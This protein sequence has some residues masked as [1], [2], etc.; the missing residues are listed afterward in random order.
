MKGCA[1]MFSV[2]DLKAY[3]LPVRRVRMSFSAAAR[4]R[5]IHLLA[6]GPCMVLIEIIV[7]Y[8]ARYPEMEPVL[9]ARPTGLS[10]GRAP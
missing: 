4:L 10:S 1:C 8:C 7:Q 2:N 9:V 6:S 5:K 3:A